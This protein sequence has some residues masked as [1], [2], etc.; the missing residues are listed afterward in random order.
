MH[1]GGA[2]WILQGVWPVVGS[3]RAAPVTFAQYSQLNGNTQQSSITTSGS[4]TTVTASGSVL[5]TF[6]AFS[7]V[8]I[9]FV[10]AANLL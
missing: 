9:P 1:W 8:L 4:S 10:L 6:S 2:T 3:A 7:W 5:F